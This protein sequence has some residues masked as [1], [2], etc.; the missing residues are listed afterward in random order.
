MEAALR[1]LTARAQVVSGEPLAMSERLDRIFGLDWQEPEA[2]LERLHFRVGQ[3]IP[4]VAPLR[5][6]VRRYYERS[7]VGVGRVPATLD[8]ALRG[9]RESFL[10]GRHWLEAAGFLVP[11]IQV[12]WMLPAEIRVL[13]TGPAPFYRYWGEGRGVLALP[14]GMDATELE[15]RR[16]ACHEGVPGHHLQAAAAEARFFQTGW[17]ELGVIAVYGPRTAVFEGLAAMAERLAADLPAPAA[18]AAPADGGVPPEAADRALRG[19]APVI[20]AIL[21]KYLDGE[22]TRLEAVRALDFE[23]LVHDPHAVLAHADRFGSY[24]LARPEADP[25]FLR[26]LETLL[27]PRLPRDRKLEHIVLAVGEAMTPRDLAEVWR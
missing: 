21:R 10:P 23:A 9:C 17:P 20:L 22:I 11:P 26:V 14:R 27:S 12:H 25:A 13:P 16:F 5:V 6:R 4:G 7:R 18:V 1:A 8:R 2:D 19:L 3:A 24:A 15:I